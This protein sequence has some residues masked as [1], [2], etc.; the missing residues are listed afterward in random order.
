MIDRFLHSFDGKSIAFQSVVVIAFIILSFTAVV[1][2]VDVI[3]KSLGK[4]LKKR[5]DEK[6]EHQL[7]TL[8]LQKA[9]IKEEW[10]N[11]PLTDKIVGLIR[12]DKE[13]LKAE[14]TFY[15]IILFYSGKEECRDFYQWD[16]NS[17]PAG[18]YNEFAQ[19]VMERLGNNYRY[20]PSTN[21]T[22]GIITVLKGE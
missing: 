7:R 19:A 8:Q 21:T 20:E 13:L 15:G 16:F 17:V 4:T 9:A 12:N 5:S 3:L 1:I 18:E 10:K 22:S 2:I 6:S 11:S 14:L